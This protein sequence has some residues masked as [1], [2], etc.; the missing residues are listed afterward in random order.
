MKRKDLRQHM[1]ENV[2]NHAHLQADFN[3]KLKTNLGV[4]LKETCHFNEKVTRLDLIEARL[5]IFESDRHH[6]INEWLVQQA[7]WIKLA[8]RTIL[9]G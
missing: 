5:D 1:H 2:I 6:T 9:R 8:C 3:M 4:I 7:G